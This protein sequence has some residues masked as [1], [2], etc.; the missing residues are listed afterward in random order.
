MGIGTVTSVFRT[1]QLITTKLFPVNLGFGRCYIRLL[2]KTAWNIVPNIVTDRESSNLRFSQRH[3]GKLSLAQNYGIFRY[4]VSMSKFALSVWI[5]YT[6]TVGCVFWLPN[7]WRPEYLG[8]PLHK[9]I[10]QCMYWLHLCS[11]VP[12]LTA[13]LTGLPLPIDFSGSPALIGSSFQ[14]IACFYYAFCS[15]HWWVRGFY[16]IG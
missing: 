2:I 1:L 15:A 3:F 8:T 6:S 7:S 4:P 5:T 14:I 11:A 10:L 12:L 9:L 13:L 16:D